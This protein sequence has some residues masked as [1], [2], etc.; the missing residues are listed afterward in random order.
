M[1][2]LYGNT[3]RLNQTHFQFDKI[4]PNRFTMDSKI[5]EDDV[6]SGRFVLVEYDPKGEFTESNVMEGYKQ[7]NDGTIYIDKDCEYPYIYANLEHVNTP[8]QANWNL[9]YVKYGTEYPLYYKLP[10]ESYFNQQEKNYYKLSDSLA[11]QADYIITDNQIVR[12]KNS[13]GKYTGEYYQCVGGIQGAA[14][15]FERIDIP[16]EEREYYLNYNIDKLHYGEFSDYGPGNR[17]Y[18]GTVWQKVYSGGADTYVLIAHL[19]AMI[20]TFDIVAEPPSILPKAPYIDAQSTDE[21][22]RLHMPSQWGFRIKE[23]ESVDDENGNITYPKSDQIAIDMAT[24]ETTYQDIYM[25]LGGVNSYEQQSYHKNESHKDNTNNIINITPTGESGQIYYDASGNQVTKDTMEL[26]ISLPSI[27]NMIDDG[28]DLIYGVNENSSIRPR[29]IA[30]YDGSES[31]EAKTNGDASIGGKSYNLN[32]LAGTINTA[33]NVLG[34]IVINL[35][36]YPTEE[37]IN[38]LSPYYLYKYNNN[39]YRVGEGFDVELVSEDEFQYI[40][41]DEV[42]ADDFKSNKYYKE[43]ENHIKVPATT[44]DSSLSINGY[45]LKNIKD[46]RYTP[47]RLTQFE[48]GQFYYKDGDNYYCDNSENTPLYYNR[49]Y[50]TNIQ[51][52]SYTF[53]VEYTPGRYYVLSE[54]N[55]IRSTED[56]PETTTTYYTFSS[57]SRS[58]F[59]NLPVR[60]YQP[61]IFY[62]KDNNSDEFHLGIESSPLPD[63]RYFVL[64]FDNKPKYGLNNDGEII[65]YYE[66]IDSEEISASFIDINSGVQ[67]YFVRNED[68]RSIVNEDL[69]DGFTSFSGLSLLTTIDRRNIYT[70]A[71]KY[72]K[73]FNIHV[74]NPG[75][76]YISG[77]YYIQ[78]E[79]TK[80]YI[81]YYDEFLVQNTYYTIDSV[82]AVSY[83]FYRPSFYYYEVST[84]IFDLSETARMVNNR[85]YY[86]KSKLYVYTDTSEKCPFGYEWNDNSLYIPPSITLFTKTTKLILIQLPTLGGQNSNSLFGLLL[87]LNQICGTNQEELRDN[88]TIQGS[89]NMLKDILYQIRTLKPGN[90]LYVNDF[91]QID[92]TNITIQQLKQ[93]IN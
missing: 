83:P 25:N 77:R 41:Q 38:S 30:W 45:Y 87:Q 4:Y 19:N 91:G 66:V 47:I 69:P 18:D 11:N 71:L 42:T 49:T 78:D 43:N 6:F 84:D 24:G 76:F 23:A 3:T 81:K 70:Y 72:Y 7:E 57:S 16:G 88:T 36:E 60:V 75:S 55:Y 54:G 79:Q 63:V 62:Y 35:Q 40:L 50:Y 90:I 22:Y 21:F 28:Y 27:G 93:L 2:L 17:G 89:L 39:Y 92:S 86:E 65:Q 59:D 15:T 1:G 80:D 48:S 14:A 20:P 31:L 64:F 8:L 13:E 52:T 56:M 67:D 5:W 34:Q 9:Y 68:L 53:E 26:S 73:L 32:T 44:Y 29:D 33:H 58:E 37:E 82:Q 46:V 51:T 61:G 10:N 85:T 74:Y 12:I